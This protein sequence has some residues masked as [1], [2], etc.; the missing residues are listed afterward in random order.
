MMSKS[1]Q[2]VNILIIGTIILYL[3]IGVIGYK[4]QK[5]AYLASIV[6]IIT[7]GAILLYWSL[8]QIQITQHI[9]ELREILVLLFEVVVI[10]CGVFYI[11][12]SERGGGLKIVQYLFYGIHLIV[13]VLGLIFM[14]TFKITRLI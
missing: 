1:D 12:S 14:M 3:A 2:Y 4:G 6:N 10:A 11:L 8:R 5:F 13:F 9:F 7:G